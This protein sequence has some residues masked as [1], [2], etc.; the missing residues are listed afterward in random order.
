VGYE[1]VANAYRSATI[2]FTAKELT[3][4]Y[5]DGVEEFHA[6]FV[7]YLKQ[8]LS[9]LSG[10]EWCFNDYV[11][12]A[13]GS[14][15][16]MMGH[17]IEATSVREG[18][19]LYP[20]D[21]YG[22][23]V[24]S[25]HQQYIEWTNNSAGK[26]ACLCIPSVRNG[27]FTE[28]M[29]KFLN[30]ADSCLLNINLYPTLSKQERVDIARVLNTVLSKSI[31]SVSF[32][33]GFGMTTSQLGV[34]LIHK[35]HPLRKRYDQSW[36]W[37]S[38]FYN[39]IATRTFMQVDIEALL[40]VDEKRRTEV[41]HWLEDHGLPVVKTGSYYVKSFMPE[42]RV[43]EYLEPLMREGLLRLCFKPRSV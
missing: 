14:D 8:K 23:L 16:D 41:F 15:V 28:E 25:S 19:V 9:E 7:P 35:D 40:A 38:Y 29:Y 6:S 2:G 5:S 37:Y 39:R 24:G 4:H 43:P 26:M 20:G 17:I 21:W 27:H 3:T 13:A 32:S 1:S 36:S 30:M 10:W 31:I 22:F 33:R 42:G 34:I 12:Y 18:V 11:A